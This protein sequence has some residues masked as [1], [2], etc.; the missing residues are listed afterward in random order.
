VYQER[1]VDPHVEPKLFHLACVYGNRIGKADEMEPQLIRN[2]FF[3]GEQHSKHN[4]ESGS[5][6][7]TYFAP[8]SSD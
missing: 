5:T 6:A 7:L 4:L 2:S 3:S 1:Q 8:I